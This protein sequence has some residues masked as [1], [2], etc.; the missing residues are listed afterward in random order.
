MALTLED[1]VPWNYG[2]D[3]IKKV[4]KEITGK[5]ALTAR[6]LEFQRHVRVVGGTAQ[7]LKLIRLM[8]ASMKTVKR[9]T[10]KLPGSVDADAEKNKGVVSEDGTQ[11]KTAAALKGEDGDKNSK[12]QVEKLPSKEELLDLV[13]EEMKESGLQIGGEMAEA[14]EREK[15][16]EAKR[17]AEGGPKKKPEKKKKKSKSLV[18]IQMRLAGCSTEPFTKADDEEFAQALEDIDGEDMLKTKEMLENINF[19]TPTV[20]RESLRHMDFPFVHGCIIGII[21]A[22]EYQ[23]D[24]LTHDDRDELKFEGREGEEK[25]LVKIAAAVAYDLGTIDPEAAAQ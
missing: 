13:L 4:R 18:S 7:H 11:S 14:I 21:D 10:L 16:E 8:Q 3:Y 19:A 1:E 24:I 2:D 20:T 15:A 17:I 9:A 12:K 25:F 22:A 5:D 6:K 23:R